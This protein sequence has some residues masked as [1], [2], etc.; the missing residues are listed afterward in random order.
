[1]RKLLAALL[2]TDHT[3]H[4]AQS[5]RFAR[6]RKDRH[7]DRI[8]LFIILAYNT[9]QR[10]QNELG[11]VVHIGSN[12]SD[13]CGKE[14]VIVEA[15]AGEWCRNQSGGFRPNTRSIACAHARLHD[16]GVP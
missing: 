12:G 15:T 6:R 5:N 13:S 4:P 1:M 11:H 3:P 16:F 10:I 7:A 9:L 8:H 2:S 14:D